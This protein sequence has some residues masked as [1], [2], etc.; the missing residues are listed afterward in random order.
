M[1]FIDRA[2]YLALALCMAI[3]AALIM[4]WAVIG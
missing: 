4:C 3:E 1:N 2:D